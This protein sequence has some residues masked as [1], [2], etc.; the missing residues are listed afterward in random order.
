MAF[1][2]FSTIKTRTNFERNI[3]LILKRKGSRL[4]KPC[5]MTSQSKN[6]DTVNQKLDLNSSAPS[7]YGSIS[8]DS[9]SDISETWIL[10]RTLGDL[11][12][13]LRHTGISFRGTSNTTGIIQIFSKEI[14]IFDNEEDFILKKFFLSVEQ[15]NN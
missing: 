13:P 5:N 6:L 10:V 12:R 9:S 3:S 4:G 7:S 1:K 8:S 2:H 15:S 14:D 11:S